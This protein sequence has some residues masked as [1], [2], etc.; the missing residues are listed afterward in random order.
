MQPFIYRPSTSTFFLDAA[1]EAE[2]LF[3][4][5]NLSNCLFEQL[6]IHSSVDQFLV[7][8]ILVENTFGFG[9]GFGGDW[10]RA[11][12]TNRL[13]G[14][15]CWMGS[16]FYRWIDYHEGI[17]FSIELLACGRTFSRFGG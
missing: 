14:K 6:N 8:V 11:L 13:I 12:P 7:A 5:A 2:I 3:V 1:K 15:C 16:H 4:I 17:A 9:F 10:G